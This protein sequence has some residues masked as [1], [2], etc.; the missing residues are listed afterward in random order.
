MS[1]WSCKRDCPPCPS[2]LFSAGEGTGTVSGVFFSAYDENESQWYFPAF[3]SKSDYTG[4][5]TE[6]NITSNGQLQKI[7]VL[8][9]NKSEKKQ[10][11]NR[12]PTFVTRP[13]STRCV[14]SCSEQLQ[15]EK[16]D[17]MLQHVQ[18]GILKC[19]MDSCSVML[20]N[21]AK[22]KIINNYVCMSKC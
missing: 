8:E 2:P 4:S 18:N 6:I 21:K 17:T 5:T 12:S 14:L 15:Q 19:P 11:P 13:C 20:Y 16:E 22:D 7:Y 3:K 9:D 1:S 10:K